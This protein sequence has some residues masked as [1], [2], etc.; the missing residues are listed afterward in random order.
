VTRRAHPYFGYLTRREDLQSSAFGR[1]SP[2]EPLLEAESQ[3]GMLWKSWSGNQATVRASVP[4]TRAYRIVLHQNLLGSDEDVDL[5]L[6]NVTEALA[7]VLNDAYLRAADIWEES[8][9]VC[10][11]QRNPFEVT[12][13]E[14][15]RSGGGR[16]PDRCA[17]ASDAAVG[18]SFES[19]GR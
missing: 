3:D 15:M 6:R 14:E 9:L 2:Y 1:R 8:E 11:V 7:Y 10:R 17:T 18:M 12:M 19:S 5:S 4:I 13:C 16:M